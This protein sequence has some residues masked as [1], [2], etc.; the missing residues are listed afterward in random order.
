VLFFAG[1]TAWRLD[2]RARAELVPSYIP[3]NADARAFLDP[4]LAARI[5]VIVH[6]RPP[7]GPRLIALTFDDGPYPVATP[8]LLDRLHDLGIH[9][10]F[11]LIGN[12]ALQYPE[13]T[14]RIVADG[15]ELGNHTFTHP[16][17]DKLDG[18]AVT[19]ELTRARESLEALAGVRTVGEVMRPPHG[20]YTLDTVE[21]AQRDGYDVALWTDDPGD[22][23]NVGVD[24][25]AEHVFAY[26]TAPEILLLHSG[27]MPTVALLDRLVPRFRAAG[28]R[29]VTLGEIVREAGPAALNGAAHIRLLPAGP[30]VPPSPK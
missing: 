12:D 1:W 3:R 4:P 9:A 17:L 14:R 6:G 13:I 24:S 20:R 16:D 29:F 23:R 25:L 19:Q 7:P 11:F 21:T 10:T 8:L 28:Y 15:N 26:A 22:W 30:E 18:P 27:R 5:D 2:K